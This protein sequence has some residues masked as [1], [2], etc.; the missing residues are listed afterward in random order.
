MFRRPGRPHAVSTFNLPVGRSEPGG[1]PNRFHVPL[2][3]SAGLLPPFS[4]KKDR[5]DGAAS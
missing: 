1:R 4:W 2:P 5:F 3:F